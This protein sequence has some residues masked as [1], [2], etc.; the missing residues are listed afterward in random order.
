[1]FREYLDDERG[2]VLAEWGSRFLP[3][4][5]HEYLVVELG[6][7]AYGP[8]DTRSIRLSICGEG[9]RYSPVFKGLQAYVDA[10][11]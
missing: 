5:C 4:L 1:M 9:S 11:S 10:H 7:V 8:E 3:E 2:I 6:Y